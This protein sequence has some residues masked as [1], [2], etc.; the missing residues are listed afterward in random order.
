[1]DIFLKKTFKIRKGTIPMT[2]F[3]HLLLHLITAN[4]SL[5]A[6]LGIFTMFPRMK[7]LRD[8]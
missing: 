7:E 6:L 5:N 4:R 8:K 2:F 1:M 3:T